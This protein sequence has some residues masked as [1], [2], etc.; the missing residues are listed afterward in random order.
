MSHGAEPQYSGSSEREAGQSQRLLILGCSKA[1]TTDEGLIPALNRYDGTAFRVLRR[2]L[3]QD[4]DDP[5]L[6]YILSA[7]FGLIPADQPIP[8]YDR[9]MS[10]IRAIELQPQVASTLER[11]S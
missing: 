1:K 9:R 6:V 4:P 10:S 7:E 2:Y 5:P 3:R 11:R 8:Y